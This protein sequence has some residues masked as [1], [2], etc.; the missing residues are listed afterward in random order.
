MRSDEIELAFY[1]NH[2]ASHFVQAD[3]RFSIYAPVIMNSEVLAYQGELADIRTL[4]V[5]QQRQHLK[6]LATKTYPQ[7][8]T[9]REIS[10]S[11]LPYSLSS[12]QIDA[13]VMDVTKADLLPDF[14]F[15]PISSHDYIS[16]VLV[17]RN[18]IVQ[19][20]EFKTFVK[21]YNIAA[22][23]MMQKIKD[24]EEGTEL[25]QIANTKFL[26]LESSN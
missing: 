1:C 26:S 21:N 16:Y 8:E 10:P 25:F 13:A 19:T 7:I 12:E 5:G 14:S 22:E 4:G 9:V 20:K 17:V 2:L 23:Q 11:A 15:A 18:D 6:Q 24:K 3:D